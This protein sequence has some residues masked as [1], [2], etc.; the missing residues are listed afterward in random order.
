MNKVP[1]FGSILGNDESR[2]FTSITFALGGMRDR[3]QQADLEPDKSRSV[4]S[5]ILGAVCLTWIIK[6][7]ISLVRL[8]WT[9]LPPGSVGL[10]FIRTS[11]K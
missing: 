6:A 8:G 4:A 2:S 1:H 5:D 3:W 11:V 7:E 9:C 10:Y